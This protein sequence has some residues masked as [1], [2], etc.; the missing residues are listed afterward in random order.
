MDFSD[1]K[2]M[3][4]RNR[5]TRIFD[6]SRPIDN[7]TLLELVELTRFCASGRNIQPL[8]YRIVNSPEE[9]KKVFPA[10]KWAGYYTDWDGPEPTQ[11]PVAYLIQ[12]LDTNITNTLL[13]D[14]GIQLE[15]IT[16]GATAKGISGCIIKAFNPETICR[17][18]SLPDNLKPLYVLA[19]GYGCEKIK[20]TEWDNSHP[21]PFRYFHDA[22]GV[23]CVPK[24]PLSDLLIEE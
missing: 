16:L 8:R 14:D 23:H 10:L 6:N 4:R 12:C 21:E 13:C 11:R 15:A 17:E 19:L 3:M 1:F 7:K 24:R 20:L 9:C 18:L 22:E 5:S 2:K